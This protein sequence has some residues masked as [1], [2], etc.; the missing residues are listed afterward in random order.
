[1]PA[2]S[3]MP[4]SSSAS[5]IRSYTVCTRWTRSPNRASRAPRALE[6]VGVAVETDEDQVGEP[7]EERLRVT[8]E[9]ERRIDEDGA[10][11]LEGRGEQLDGAFEQDGDV[12]RGI[13]HVLRCLGPRCL[14]PIRCD[15][16]S[17]KRGRVRG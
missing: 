13:G 15:L 12:T 3:A 7:V 5:A 2:A 8:A 11:A 17:G 16:S 4:S 6:R 1:M 14:I 10:G 9:P